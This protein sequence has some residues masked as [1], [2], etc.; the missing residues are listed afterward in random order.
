MPMTKAAVRKLSFF[1]LLRECAACSLHATL[2]VCMQQRFGADVF[3]V[4]AMD[5]VQE[6]SGVV[7]GEIVQEFM[8]FGASK[9]G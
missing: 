9:R 1:M 5:A 8:V 2:D 6:W 7:M 3:Q 4:R